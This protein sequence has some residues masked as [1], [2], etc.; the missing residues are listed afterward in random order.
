MFQQSHLGTAARPTLLDYFLLLAGCSLSLFLIQIKPWK[1]EAKEGL[2]APAADLVG[3]L[4]DIMRLTEGVVLLW[5]IFLA[6]QSLRGRAH[7][8]SAGEWLWVIAWLGVATMTG[9]A[10]WAKWGTLPEWLQDHADKPRMI[11]YMIVAPSMGALAMLFAVIGLVR[12]SPI[13]WTQSFSL[14]L[15]TWPVLPLAGILTLGK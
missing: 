2:G 13:P 12:R 8:L 5:P 14:A 4:G 3:Q 6:L 1:F 11:Y 15:V 9:L 10:A 7:G